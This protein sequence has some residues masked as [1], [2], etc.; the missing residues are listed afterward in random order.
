MIGLGVRVLASAQR[1]RSLERAVRQRTLDYEAEATR[2]RDQA[3]RL[4][5]LDRQRQWF[6]AGAMHELRTPLAIIHGAVAERNDGKG[7]AL[8]VSEQAV[9]LVRSNA[10]RLRGTLDE[11]AELAE[12]DL[13]ARQVQATPVDVEVLLRTVVQAAAPLAASDDVEIRLAGDEQARWANLDERAVRTIARNLISNAIRHTGRG[14]GV[15]VN[16]GTENEDG[17]RIFVEDDGPGVPPE[18]RDLVFERFTQGGSPDSVVGR[19]GVGLALVLELV[20][21]H[22]G[23]VEIDQ[24]HPSRFVVRIP[25]VLTDRHTVEA[26]Q[27]Q[28]AVSL[29]PPQSTHAAAGEDAPLV[30][31]V[32][33]EEDLRTLLVLHLRDTFRTAEVADG[34]KALSEIRRLRPDLVLLD[35]MLPGQ[36]GID[37]LTQL[38]AAP[39]IG[40]IPV[41]TL[42]ARSDM[43][44]AAYEAQTDAHIQKPWNRATLI[45]QIQSAI[46]IRRLLQSRIPDDEGPGVLELG[47]DVRFKQALR[48]T[49]AKRLSDPTFN[50]NALAEAMAMGRSTFFRWMKTVEGNTASQL[51]IEMRMEKAGLLLRNGMR[52]VNTVARQVGYD[53]ADRFRSHFKKHFGVPP[54]V[55]RDQEPNGEP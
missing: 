55:Y 10:D 14:G 18:K 25:D 17:L 16:Y 24:A 30:L 28:E 8:P 52:T 19:S 21:L 38:R 40:H 44:V 29:P 34:A 23:T 54:S 37:V 12:L 4:E 2:N 42:T 15:R 36:G 32:E 11:L 41:I 13:G 49:I 50:V 3:K 20:T 26:A 1:T 48:Q 46:D 31:I 22:G 39:G 35:I 53:S 47:L 9:Q 51:I 27:S 43:G 5:A 33:D 7:E 6:L 45:A